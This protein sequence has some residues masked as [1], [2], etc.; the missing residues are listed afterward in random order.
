MTQ[1]LDDDAAKASAAAV[2]AAAERCGAPLP[3]QL[4]G[5]RGGPADPHGATGLVLA[6]CQCFQGG[7]LILEAGQLLLELGPELDG[8]KWLAGCA[9]CSSP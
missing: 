9:K 4:C 1:G 3:Q 5:G 7:G 8:G 6:G 2:A